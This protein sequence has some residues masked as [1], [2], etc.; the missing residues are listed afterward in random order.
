MVKIIRECWLSRSSLHIDLIASG[1]PD[2]S[3]AAERSSTLLA[4][5]F[6]IGMKAMTKGEFEAYK[7]AQIAALLAGDIKRQEVVK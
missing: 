4:A 5:G 6:C 7:A 1:S 3:P 2:L